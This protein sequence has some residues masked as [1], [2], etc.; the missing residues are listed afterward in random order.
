MSQ[1]I[2]ALRFEGA[3]PSVGGSRCGACGETFDTPLLAMVFSESA[4]EEYYACPKCLSKVASIRK[5][6]EIEDAF[7]FDAVETEVAEPEAPEVAVE[8]NVEGP[9]S[10]V[11][12]MGYLKSRP[13]NTP[14]PEECLT[15]SKMID[16]MY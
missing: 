16:C 4:T 6:P 2:A 12:Y 9:G 5:A 14:I 3:V 1:N 11:H 10:C 7:E 15:C 13:K 8:S